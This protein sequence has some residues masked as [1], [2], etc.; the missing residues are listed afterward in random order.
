MITGKAAV[1]DRTSQQEVEGYNKLIKQYED[2]MLM[3]T[4]TP[5]ESKKQ[6]KIGLDQQM[7]IFKKNNPGFKKDLPK[8]AFKV[9]KTI[10]TKEGFDLDIHTMRDKLK[11]NDLK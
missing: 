2:I 1:L 3:N 4:T 5:A 8:N 11:S 7:E 6:G 10:D 9:G